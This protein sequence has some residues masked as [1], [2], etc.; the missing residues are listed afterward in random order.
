M[1][2]L[3]VEDVADRLDNLVH[4]D[5]QRT[6]TG[7]D[8]TVGSVERLLGAG[9]LDFGGGE[10]EQAVT[11]EVEPE[12]KSEDDEYGWWTL[13]GGFFRI[14]YN[15]SFV[16]DE[17]EYGLVRPLERLLAAGATHAEFHLD[18]ETDP[19]VALLQVGPQGVELKENFRASRLQ[20]YRRE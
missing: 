2:W 4:F 18:G 8:L 9:A 6:P 17:G 12:L 10:F 11:Q 5:T 20:I 16:P 15:E 14:T 1:E 3:D 13:E 19:I 7:I